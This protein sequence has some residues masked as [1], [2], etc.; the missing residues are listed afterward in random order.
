MPA[1]REVRFP[2]ANVFQ[3]SLGIDQR[4]MRKGG[5]MGEIHVLDCA[6]MLMK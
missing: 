4:L 3:T 5:G 1:G 6:F 2:P